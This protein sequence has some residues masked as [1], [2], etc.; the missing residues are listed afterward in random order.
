M[1]VML[2]T[3]GR[4]GEKGI[5]RLVLAAL[6]SEPVFGLS[7]IECTINVRPAIGKGTLTENVIQRNFSLGYDGVNTGNKSR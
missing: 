5:A 1:T 3:I 4:I 2:K 6:V 7:R